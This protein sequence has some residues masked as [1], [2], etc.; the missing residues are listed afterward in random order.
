M[1]HFVGK[2]IMMIELIDG[3]FDQRLKDRQMIKHCCWP[4]AITYDVRS[5]GLG[6]ADLIEPTSRG[7]CKATQPSKLSSVSKPIIVFQLFTTRRD[8]AVNSSRVQLFT[9]AVVPLY[10]A[11]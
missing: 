10:R 9:A 2:I 6:C 7:S 4:S 1:Q 11:P 3:N 8:A 5:L